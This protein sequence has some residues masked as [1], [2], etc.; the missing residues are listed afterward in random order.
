MINVEV[1]GIPCVFHEEPVN[2]FELLEVIAEIEGGNV[3]KLPQYFTT[4]FGEE[5]AANIKESLRG[6]D[7]VC[8]ITDMYAFYQASLDAA[9]N[10]KKADAK[11]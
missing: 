2:D 6:E 3:L 1:M 8:R 9:A 10:A 7:G 5:Q 11:N 4:V